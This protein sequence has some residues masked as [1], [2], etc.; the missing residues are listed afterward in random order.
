[1]LNSIIYLPRGLKLDTDANLPPLSGLWAWDM[2]MKK[3]KK[4]IIFIF[5]QILKIRVGGSV[6]QVIKKRRP[7]YRVNY[8][9]YI[10][11]IKWC[12]GV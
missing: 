9:D 6:N 1:M 10:I 5:F 7:K 12:F 4:N 8:Y 2:Q 11:I 3:K